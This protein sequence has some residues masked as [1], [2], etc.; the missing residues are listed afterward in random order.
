[1]SLPNDTI[2]IYGVTAVVQVQLPNVTFSLY[3]ST[4]LI[5]AIPVVLRSSTLDYS[6]LY[7]SDVLYS[8]HSR[9][10]QDCIHWGCTGYPAVADYPAIFCVS[11]IRQT[12][13][14]LIL[15]T[16]GREPITRPVRSTAI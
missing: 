12:R 16:R 9:T 14:P 6:R 11:G 10:D 4:Q 15:I 7:S 3:N 5:V 1:M 8:Y 2:R 13:Q